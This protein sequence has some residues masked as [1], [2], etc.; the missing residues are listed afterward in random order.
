MAF[1]NLFAIPNTFSEESRSSHGNG[2]LGN[3][4]HKLTRFKKKKFK[5]NLILERH[6]RRMSEGDGL[7]TK[8]A[9][10]REISR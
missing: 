1:A 8:V 6:S 10:G 4:S 5:K 3:N 2:S 7:P 9:A